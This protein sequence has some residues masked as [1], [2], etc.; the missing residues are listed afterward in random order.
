MR[1]TGP[2]KF[3]GHLK[4]ESGH[5]FL[6]GMFV[7]ADI[8]IAESLKKALP[9]GAVANLDDTWYL[10]RLLSKNE[11]EYVF[12]KVEIQQGDQYNG[13]TSIE[14]NTPLGAT[15]KFLTK[16]IFNVFNE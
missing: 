1:R 12:K 7:E 15:D 16:G 13:Y 10:L 4:N 11:E 6:T 5:N 14:T 9:S 2:L 3:D 8:V